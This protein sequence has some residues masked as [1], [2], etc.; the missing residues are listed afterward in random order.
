MRRHPKDF[1]VVDVTAVPPTSYE[2]F[3][4]GKASPFRR[5]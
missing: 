1:I 2:D 4:V 5:I 3:M